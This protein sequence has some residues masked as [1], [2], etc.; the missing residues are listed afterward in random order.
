M[1]LSLPPSLADYVAGYRATLI[2]DGES[3]GI[4]HRLDTDGRPSLFLKQGAGRV[5]VDIADEYARLRWLAGRW[6]VP[7][8]VGY[9][10]TEAGAWLLTTALPGRAAY[11]WLGDHPE[12]RE[13]AVRSIAAFLR[14]LHAEPID[15]C[16]FNAALPLRRAA[17]AANFETGLVDLDDL[18]PEREGW[19]GEQLWAHFESLLPLEADPVVTHGDFSLDNIFLDADGAVT[20]CLDVGRVGVADRYQDL[21]IL[22]HSLR[23]FGDDLADTMLASYG[24]ALDRKKIDLHLVLDEFF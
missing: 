18:D 3:G 19:S 23:E 1:T 2:T 13:V 10:D 5:A 24:V 11:G 16:P 9:A 21:A 6:A 17:A 7:Q 15:T 20:G 14:Q 12:Q 22:W 4:V 8:V